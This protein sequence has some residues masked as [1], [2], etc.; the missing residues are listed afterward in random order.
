MDI[1]DVPEWNLFMT[2]TIDRS[3]H[4]RESMNH[5]GCARQSLQRTPSGDCV[6]VFLWSVY[7]ALLLPTIR[8]LPLC[9]FVRTYGVLFVRRLYAL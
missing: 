3:R 1:I 7:G 8:G 6:Y 4:H 5:S 9:V 2:E